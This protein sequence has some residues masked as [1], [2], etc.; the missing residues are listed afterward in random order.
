MAGTAAGVRTAAGAA[1]AAG[2]GHCNLDILFYAIN[3]FDLS[4]FGLC[5]KFLVLVDYH[6]WSDCRLWQYF[7]RLQ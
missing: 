5:D 2:A 1:A 3:K 4:I 6:I 7:S